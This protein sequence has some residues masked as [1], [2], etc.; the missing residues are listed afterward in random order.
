M[1]KA[2]LFATLGAASLLGLAGCESHQAKVD[3]IQKEYEYNG[4]QDSTIYTA[5]RIREKLKNF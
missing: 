3:R 5:K 2:A 1:L 4:I